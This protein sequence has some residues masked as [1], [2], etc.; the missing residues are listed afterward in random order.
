[1]TEE[2]PLVLVR[3]S[4]EGHPDARVR[5]V[6]AAIVLPCSLALLYPDPGTLRVT[7]AV[8]PIRTEE[9]PGWLAPSPEG[10]LRT[11]P[12]RLAEQG[13]MDGFFIARFVNRA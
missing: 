13:G 10:W 6:A 8:A 9:L 3:S 2:R 7:L 1:M 12:G 5:L 11:D 4:A